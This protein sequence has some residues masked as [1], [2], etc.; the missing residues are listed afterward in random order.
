MTITNLSPRQQLSAG[1]L[2][3]RFTTLFLGL[4]LYA[5]A[6][7]MLIR[8]QLGVDPWDVLHLGIANHVPLSLSTIVIFT[9][10]LVLLAWIP[11]KQWPG[12]GTIANT[13]Y[14]GL[15]LDFFLRILPE[16]HGLGLQLLVVAVA[17][18]VNG[19][20]GALYI[21]SHFGAGPRDG[22]M[23]GLHRHTGVSIRLV[24]T[25]LE[26]SVLAIGWLLGGPVGIGTVAYALLIG[27]ATQLFIR[28]TS[29]RLRQRS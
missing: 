20:G 3:L 10:A 28:R 1:R 18:L 21:G 19:L 8:A 25:A 16:V 6:M 23:T 4:T 11:L 26:L 12:L 24:R 15:A 7:A 17:I 9:G 27:P 22:L 13:L 29:I 2:P 5:L 14:L